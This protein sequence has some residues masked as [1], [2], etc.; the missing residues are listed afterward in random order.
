MIRFHSLLYVCAFLELSHRNNAFDRPHTLNC[1]NIFLHVV[2]DMMKRKVYAVF[3]EPRG[4]AKRKHSLV[5]AS[6]SQKSTTSKSSQQSRS[7]VFDYPR[8]P[9]GSE[10]PGSVN[11]S[12]SQ[13]DFDQGGDEEEVASNDDDDADDDA[14]E[15]LDAE[16]VCPPSERSASYHADKV[17]RKR[18]QQL[19]ADFPEVRL[20]D[21]LCFMCQICNGASKPKKKWNVGK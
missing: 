4:P 5:S 14:D 11:D 21:R 18:E 6:P 2:T 12:N 19:Q 7:S 20:L 16:S 8:S 1:F 3:Q 9:S 10:D 13:D 17:L 15:E